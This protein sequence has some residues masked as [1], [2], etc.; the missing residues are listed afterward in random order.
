MLGRLFGASDE[1]R[2]ISFQQVWGSGIDVSGMTTWSGTMVNS[3]N[4][5][6]VGAAYAC[7]PSTSTSRLAPPPTPTGNS[8]ASAAPRPPVCTTGS[9]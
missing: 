8:T 3:Q 4:A 7:V 1:Q 2:D 9:I 5:L 6:Q